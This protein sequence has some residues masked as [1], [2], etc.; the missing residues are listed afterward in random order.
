[1][2][3]LPFVTVRC[4]SCGSVNVEADKPKH[5]RCTHCES[6]FIH[7][8]VSAFFRPQNWRRPPPPTPP[9]TSHAVPYHPPQVQV[10]TGGGTAAIIVLVIV[11]SVFGGIGFTIY[12]VISSA[13][14]QTTN[15]AEAAI[16]AINDPQVQKAQAQAAKAVEQARASA[17]RAAATAKAAGGQASSAEARA[18]AAASSKRETPE[19]PE[20]DPGPIRVEAYQPL[21]GCSCKADYDGDGKT[22]KVQLAVKASIVGT[23]ITSSGTSREVAY[24][25]ILRSGDE[26]PVRLPLTKETA[27]PKRRRGENLKLG[28]GCESGR[29]YFAADS[30][31]SAFSLR[32]HKYVWKSDLPA[33]FVKRGATA[34]SGPTIDCAV[35]PIKKGQVSVRLP[36]GTIKLSTEDGSES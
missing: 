25:F 26:D 1:M 18:K 32:D 16:Q 27:P 2:A 19:P 15:Q 17:E 12:M 28:M 33:P 3:G 35:L 34:K 10:S 14:E 30:V 22:E 9:V 6:L 8:P 13:V 36:G 20:P 7:N 4:P 24:D 5:Y 23:W 29:L 21:S 11:L 31:V